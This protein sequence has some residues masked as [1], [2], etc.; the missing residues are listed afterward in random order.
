MASSV[1]PPRASPLLFPINYAVAGVGRG[2]MLTHCIDSKPPRDDPLTFQA[3]ISEECS[4]NRRLLPNLPRMS[5]EVVRVLL[6]RHQ[7]VVVNC[8]GKGTISCDPNGDPG[9][10][11]RNL[12]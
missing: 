12:H 6:T 1:V 10:G 4:R 5:D 2:E 8:T 11:S 9:C 7:L 3:W